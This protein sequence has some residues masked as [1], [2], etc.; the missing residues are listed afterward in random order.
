MRHLVRLSIVAILVIWFVG[1]EGR[2]SYMRHPLVAQAKVVAGPIN[3][4]EILTQV[5]PYPPP[6]P[7]LEIEASNLITVPMIKSSERTPAPGSP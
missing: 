5:E 2:K 1:C 7:N 6:R 3:E 4:P